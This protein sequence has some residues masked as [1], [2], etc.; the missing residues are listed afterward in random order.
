M[1]FAIKCNKCQ[2]E[3][4]EKDIEHTGSTICDPSC[5]CEGYEYALICDC[6]HELYEGSNWGEFDLE[7]VIEEIKGYFTPP[8]EKEEQIDKEERIIIFG[9]NIT[10]GRT[11]TQ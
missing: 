9:T 2:G 5:G 8:K 10:W 7:V 4:T 3:V 6:G 11:L 1:S